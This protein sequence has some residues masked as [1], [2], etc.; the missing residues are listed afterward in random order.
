M[1]ANKDEILSKKEKAKQAREKEN[2]EKNPLAKMGRTTSADDTGYKPPVIMRQPSGVRIDAGKRLRLT[3]SATGIPLPQYRW[4]KNGA[5]ITGANGSV[6]TIP[7]ARPA[8]TGVYS[9]DA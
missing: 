3:V 7:N 1:P 8:A 4:K 2:A 5:V 9:V 6:L